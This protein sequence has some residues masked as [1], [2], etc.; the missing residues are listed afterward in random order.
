MNLQTEFERVPLSSLHALRQ[1]Y[2]D[3]LPA[4]Q[5]LMIELLVQSGEAYLV[6]AKGEVCGYFVLHDAHTLIEFYLRRPYW[7]FG[8]HVFR[9]ILARTPVRRALVKS[10]DHLFLSS[11]IAH[12]SSVKSLGLLVRDY[13]ARPLP[14]IEAIRFETRTASSDD[15]PRIRA[16][17]Q[18]VFTDPV[19]LAQVVAEGNMLLFEG[20]AEARG[21]LI[22]FGIVRPVIAGRPEV[23]LGVA[24]AA[25]Y[26]NRGYAI[27]IFQALVA[28]AF[29]RG[30][31]PVA[32]CSEVNAASRRMGE[33]VGMVARHRLLELAFAERTAES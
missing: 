31:K 32:G 13:V 25:P 30:L 2:L 26:R 5:E 14:V 19:R 23:D 11:S 3:A 10:Y 4:A 20:A 9:Q 7:V 6:E 24:V 22:G 12:Q 21:S 16:V 29:A 17:E 15:L 8:E 18:A 1:E 27:Y 33:R 28:H